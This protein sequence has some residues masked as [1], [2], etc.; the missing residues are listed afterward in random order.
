[1][2]I[3]IYLTAGEEYAR[4]KSPQLFNYL[5][6]N[7][8]KINIIAWDG[9]LKSLHNKE[10]RNTGKVMVRFS[11]MHIECTDIELK[12]ECYK[13]GY[14]LFYA[15]GVC[16]YFGKDKSEIPKDGD[17]LFDDSNF[18]EEVKNFLA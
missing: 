2:E 3:N 10:N 14:F 16:K 4:K 9:T 1:M 7:N 8:I 13:Y 6:D 15:K 17:L 5:D 11:S 12:K 18:L